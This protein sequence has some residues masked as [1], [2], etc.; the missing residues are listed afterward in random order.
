MAEREWSPPWLAA[1]FF[2]LAPYGFPRQILMILDEGDKTF[3]FEAIKSK[4]G[5]T[6]FVLAVKR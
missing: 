4:A 2:R 1:Q 3:P 5:L 6:L